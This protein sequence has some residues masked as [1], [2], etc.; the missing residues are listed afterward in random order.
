MKR[1]KSMELRFRLNWESDQEKWTKIEK[2]LIQLKKIFQSNSGDF[3]DYEKGEVKF[4]TLLELNQQEIKGILKEQYPDATI[5]IQ[6][7]VYFLQL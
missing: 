3:M 4:N 1:R 6:D 7:D 2:E 5:K